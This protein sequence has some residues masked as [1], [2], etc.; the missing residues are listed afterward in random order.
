MGKSLAIGISVLAVYVLLL[1]RSHYWDGV[2]FSLYIEKVARG[3]MSSSVLFHPN[4]LLYSAG[5]FVL[6][7]ILSP[8]HVRAMTCPSAVE[9]RVRSCYRD[10]PTKDGL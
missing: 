4:H 6:Y 7:Q 10:A 8:F 9:C 3:E 5:G 2:L 1:T